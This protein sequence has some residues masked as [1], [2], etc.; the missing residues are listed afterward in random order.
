MD[1]LVFDTKARHEKPN[2]KDVNNGFNSQKYL[3]EIYAIG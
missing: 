1:N 3:V 2:T